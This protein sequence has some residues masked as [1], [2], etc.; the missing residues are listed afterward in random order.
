LNVFTYGTLMDPEIMHR[1]SGGQ[2]QALKASLKNF[3]RKRVHGE[4]YPGIIKQEDCYVEGIVYLDVDPFALARLDL[5]EGSQYARREV[6]LGSTSGA[7]LQ[8]QT[9][10]IKAEHGVELTGEDWNFEDFLKT[11]KAVF[12]EQYPG[13]EELGQLSEECQG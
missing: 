1:V 5:F 6:L 4:V 2:F 3:S 10:V 12:F 13:F 7:E 11:G 8:A 9:Y